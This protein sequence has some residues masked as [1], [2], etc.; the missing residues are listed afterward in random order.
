[1][2]RIINFIRNSTNPYSIDLNVFDDGSDSGHGLSTN[3]ALPSSHTSAF[4][5]SNGRAH[6]LVAMISTAVHE[7][8]THSHLMQVLKLLN[9]IMHNGTS[10]WQSMFANHYTTPIFTE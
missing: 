1:M 6:S 8:R 5:A 2:V 3:S 7:Q 9:I 4:D 10:T